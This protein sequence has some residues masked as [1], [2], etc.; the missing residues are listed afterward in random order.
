MSVH[1]PNLSTISKCV[2]LLNK[3]ARGLRG[4]GLDWCVDGHLHAVRL[5]GFDLLAR[6]LDR[7][8]DGVVVEGVVGGDDLGRLLLEA[9]LVR[10]DAYRGSA[11]VPG[12]GA[13]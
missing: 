12:S 3:C 5:A 13:G 2:Y 4:R 9:D 6:L 7:G 11:V 8:E 1:P 10:L